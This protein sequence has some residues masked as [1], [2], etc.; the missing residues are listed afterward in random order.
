MPEGKAN[1]GTEPHEQKTPQAGGKEG[2][3]EVNLESMNKTPLKEKEKGG[4]AS[5]RRRRRK[6]LQKKKVTERSPKRRQPFLRQLRR[7]GLKHSA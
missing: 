5:R 4:K 2:E 1:K 3:H 7:K 6:K